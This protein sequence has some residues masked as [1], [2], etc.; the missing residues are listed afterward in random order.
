MPNRVR[1]T[2]V[3]QSADGRKRAIG[4]VHRRDTRMVNFRKGWR[5]HLWQ[6]RCAP[7]VLDEPDLLIDA[8]R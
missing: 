6:G 7:F 8:P 5:G 1:L 3:P 2:A 4:E